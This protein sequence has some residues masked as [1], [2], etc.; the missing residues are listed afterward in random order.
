MTSALGID[1]GGSGMKAA[2]VDL[3]RGKTTDDRFRIV[4]PQPATPEAMAEVVGELV[5]HFE[6]TGPVGVGFPGV[7]Q[8][9]IVRTAANLD[10]SWVDV[11]GDGLFTQVSGCDV[12]LI[13]DADA[14]GSAELRFGAGQGER[15]VVVMLTLGTGIG[16]AI[17]TD[18]VL[19]PNTE[20]GHL[21]MGGMI[22]EDR[23]SSRAK[24]EH[25]LSFEEWG[26]EL[27]RY[28]LEI[29][30]LFSPNL[31][32]LGG[33]ISKQFD[34]FD[35]YLSQVR[36]RVVPAKMR[37]KAGIIGAALAQA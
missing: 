12:V 4:T 6:W 25:D 36:A 5:R 26:A 29:E 3:D 23:A 31:V 7:I 37:N 8:S 30:M 27:E 22:A 32:I 17:F 10:P 2:P 14:A 18:G 24:D 11:D 13:N 19:V 35:H 15:G 21:D 20:F 28:L 1:I 34:Q 16:S 9:G 33:G